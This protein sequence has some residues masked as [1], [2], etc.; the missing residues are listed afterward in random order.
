MPMNHALLHSASSS[1]TSSVLG[2]HEPTGPAPSVVGSISKCFAVLSQLGGPGG[3]SHQ[4]LP[5]TVVVPHTPV[6]CQP[7]F[8]VGG[9]CSW[10][11]VYPDCSVE[12]LARWATGLQLLLAWI[13][14]KGGRVCL[15]LGQRTK[16][17]AMGGRC[18]WVVEWKG[19]WK[20]WE[21]WGPDVKEAVFLPDSTVLKCLFQA[22]CQSL[23]DTRPIPSGRHDPPT[24]G[25]LQLE[26]EM[27]SLKLEKP[28]FSSQSY[29]LSSGAS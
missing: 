20:G 2:P 18:L 23:G 26:V 5:P 4:P 21:R 10:Q 22:L 29:S 19:S 24:L 15:C 7:L 27:G 12:W 8:T 14:I 3:L 28:E 13:N 11:T 1:C 25:L 17:E 16:K 6:M 9:G